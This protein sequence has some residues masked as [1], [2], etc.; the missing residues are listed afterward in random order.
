MVRSMQG[1]SHDEEEDAGDSVRARER[2][3]VERLLV[4][5][6][7]RSDHAER[8]SQ[9]ELEHELADALARDVEAALSG[10]AAKELA[11]VEGGQA[12][13]SLPTRALDDLDMICI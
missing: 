11:C 6:L 10:L 3:A 13:A 4:L 5:A 8:W 1:E 12:W 9:A 2:R 7:L